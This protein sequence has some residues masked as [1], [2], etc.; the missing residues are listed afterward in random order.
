MRTSRR[1]CFLSWPWTA[2]RNSVGSFE[3][4]SRRWRIGGLGGVAHGKQTHGKTGCN[5]H[6]R[7][8]H[9]GGREQEGV[10]LLGWTQS[11]RVGDESLW[12][13]FGQAIVEQ[14]GRGQRDFAFRQG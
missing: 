2:L 14:Y 4:D 11:R 7:G 5:W 13:D 1:P 6:S 8:G 9:A 10:S 3:Q 12:L